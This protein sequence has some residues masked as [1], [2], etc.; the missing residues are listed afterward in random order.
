MTNVLDRICADKRGH[1]AER[2]AARPEKALRAIARSL[3]PPR[4]FKD[5]LDRAI[6][7]GDFGLI[8]EIKKAS[9]SQGLIRPDFDPASLARAYE[10]GGATCLSVLTDRPYFQGEDDYLGQARSAAALPV[11]RKDFMIDPYQVTEA[12]AIGADCILIIMAAVSDQLAADLEGEAIAFGMDRL[13][14]VHDVE[15]LDRAVKLRSR[16]IGVNNRDLTTLEVD[17]GTTER[18]AKRVPAGFTLVS[19]S[20]LSKTEDLRRMARAGARCFLVGEA[21]MRQ[22]DVVAATAAL[23][24]KA[25]RPAFARSA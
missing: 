6:T 15:E 4:G 24:G 7:A 20:G 2:R 14:E 10:L 22:T 23:L 1:V 19:E 18:L 8:A 21:L 13:I 16:L 5:A 11:L 9:P 12:R 3:P 25:T 17:L